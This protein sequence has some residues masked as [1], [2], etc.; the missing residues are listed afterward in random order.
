MSDHSCVL[1]SNGY[2]KR[3]DHEYPVYFWDIDLPIYVFRGVHNFD[4]RKATKGMALLNDGESSCDNSLTPN[5]CCKGGNNK[6]GPK[7]RFC[8]TSRDEK[9][10]QTNWNLRTEFWH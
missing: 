3:K 8:K 9:T 5:N 6:D 4:S 2:G 10:N 7:Y 1:K